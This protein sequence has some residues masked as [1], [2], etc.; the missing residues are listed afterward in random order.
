MK[1]FIPE[2]SY[3]NLRNVKRYSLRSFAL[4]AILSLALA[5]I[6]YGVDLWILTFLG[7]TPLGI[8]VS[9]AAFLEGILLLICG[10]L[11]LI[12]SGGISQTSRKAAML[13]ATAS[14]M[15]KDVIGPSEVYK[16]DRWKPKGFTRLGL[17]LTIAGIILLIV[18]FVSI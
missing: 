16:R 6:F 3:H 12:G 13:A 9:D 8:L 4:L 11:A 7:Y 2:I 1:L 14:A 15:S 17:T 5:G 18:Y 10:V